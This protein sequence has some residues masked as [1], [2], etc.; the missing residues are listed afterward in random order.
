MRRTDY[1]GC[2]RF[3]HAW[4]RLCSGTWKS[5]WHRSKRSFEETVTFRW[6]RF[7]LLTFSVVTAS[8]SQL[9]LMTQDEIRER[10]LREAQE[11]RERL[12]A[13][14][15]DIA[16]KERRIPQQVTLADGDGWNLS[17]VSCNL[18]SDCQREV[19]PCGFWTV[20]TPSN[21][22]RSGRTRA[23]KWRVCHAEPAGA[24]GRAQTTSK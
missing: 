5:Q 19:G 23:W 17:T 12:R 21:K 8:T 3:G 14:N 2:M 18:P 16:G 1:D 11:T 4:R 15:Q 13:E 9:R 7:L 6:R 20:R 24:G 10:R 22:A